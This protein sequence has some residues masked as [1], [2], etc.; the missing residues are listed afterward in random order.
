MATN[1]QYTKNARQAS[2]TVNTAN[3]NRDGTGSMQIAWTA[4]AFVSDINPGGSRIERV[5]LQ[6][7][8][9]T[10]AGMIRLFVSSDAA[11]NTA[12]NTFLYEEI[13]VTAA[14]PST[15]ISAW[16]ASLQAVTYQTLFPIILGP[17]CTLRVATANAESFVVTVMGGDY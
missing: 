5:L 1:A 12:A 16:A 4:P 15:T 9:T 3:T 7:T 6:A 14:A 10:T 17:G 11:A 13:P 8:G 2:V